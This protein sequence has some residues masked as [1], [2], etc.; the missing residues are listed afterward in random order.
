MKLYLNIFLCFLCCLSSSAEADIIS[1]EEG[2]NTAWSTSKG[3]LR[4]SDKKAKFGNKSLE[5]QWQS[6]AV[7][8]YENSSLL[9]TVSAQK[10]GGV[11]MWVY[12]ATPLADRIRIAFRDQNNILRCYKDFTLNFTGWRCFLVRMVDDMRLPSR[13]KGKI[14]KMSIRAPQH[15]SGTLLFD[16]VEFQNSVTWE[17][18]SDFQ[19]TVTESSGIDSYLACHQY[20]RPQ[21]S[22]VTL[23]KEQ[24]IAQI[25][26][27]IDQWYTGTQKYAADPLYK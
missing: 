15:G 25:N 27:R 8:T 26:K 22:E 7:L 2:N 3:L 1:F 10:Q 16:F 14:S 18:M 13:Y 20:L 23:E 5:W 11:M 12:N 6:D 4:I 19:Y 17:R 21:Q 24:A 9:N